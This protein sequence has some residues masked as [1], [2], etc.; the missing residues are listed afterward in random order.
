MKKQIRMMIILG[1]ALIALVAVWFGSSLIPGLKPEATTTAAETTAEQMLFSADATTVTRITVRNESGELNLTPKSVTGTDGKPAINWEVTEAAGL[2]VSQA[3]L[4]SLADAALKVTYSEV[5]AENSTDLASFG[6]ADSKTSLAV[7]GKDGS[8]RTISLGNDLS[9]GSATYARIDQENRIVAVN[10]SYKQQ[11]SATLMS[12]IDTSKV[13]GGLTFK[14]VTALTFDRQKSALHLATSCKANNPEDQTAGYTFNLSEPLVKGGNPTNLSTL[15]NSV[16]SLSSLTVVDLN[17]QDSA[18]Y[19][20]DKPQYQFKLDSSEV[21]GVTFSVGS[22]AGDGKYYLTSSALP[23]VMTVDAGLF[24]AVDMPLEDYVDRYVAL[25]D[26]WLV[27]SVDVNLGDKTFTVE[28]KMDKGQSSSDKDIVLKLDGRDA[29]IKDQK[30]SSL[31]SNFYQQLIG[32]SLTGFDFSATP[33]NT[34]DSR[35]VYHLEADPETSQPASVLTIE[36][37]RRDAYTDYVFID[38]KYAGYYVNH[39]DTFTQD[40]EGSEGLRVA[41]LKLQYAIDHAVNGVFDTEKGYQLTE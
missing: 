23:V 35:I 12:L 36:F 2:P 29:N 25:K 22:D 31:F 1:V 28:I 30:N 13:I 3:K 6:L 11:A 9:S 37:A 27:S 41:Y 20:L 17:P 14:N 32:I 10:P 26:I 5:I 39:Q 16:L 7:T 4:K 40:R 24:K 8:T 34:A 21:S 18:K 19:G 38:G 15:L 33:E